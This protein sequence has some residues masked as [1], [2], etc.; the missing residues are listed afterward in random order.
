MKFVPLHVH[1]HYSLLDGMAKIDDLVGKAKA[2]GMEAMA[3]TDHGSMYGI[4]EFYQKAKKAGLKPILGIETYVAPYGRFNKRTKIDEERYHLILLAKNNLGYRN[5]LKL[6][7]IANLEGFY[8]KPRI[9]LEILDKYKDGLIGLSACLE[10]EIPNAILTYK[11]LDKAASV[12]E[13]YLKIFGPDNFFLELQHHP[14]IKEQNFVNEEL[15]KLAK[16]SGIGLVATNDTHYL[17]TEDAKAQDI[18][19]CV[20][21]NRKIQETNRL[22][23]MN[24]EFSLRT[25]KQMIKDFKDCPEAISNTE[26]I[27]EACNV[28]IEF[29]KNILPK[30]EVPGG[31]PAIE[32]LKKLCFEGLIFRYGG[33]LEENFNWQIDEKKILTRSQSQEFRKKEI[34]ERL[35]FELSVIE[36]TGFAPYFLIVADFINWAKDNGIVVGPGRGSAAGSIVAYLTRTTDIDPLAYD[37]LFERFLNPDRISMPDID[38]DFADIR[39]DEVIHYVEEKYGKDHVAQI[40]TFGTMAARAAVRDVGRAL[41]LPYSYCDK[42][43][44]M[45]PM[46][47][48]LKVA[49]EKVLDLRE[50][51]KK[52]KD[53][54]ELLDNAIKL[55]GVCRHAST[56]ACGV[57]ITPG[58]LDDYL[59][60][61]YSTSGDNVIVSQYSLHPVEDLGL[62]KMDF[63]GL[64]NLTTIE[65]TLETIEKIH[66]TKIEIEKLPLADKKTF[67]LLQKGETTGVF[68]LESSGMKRYLRQLKPTEFEDIIAMVAM[69]RPGPMEHIP[70][71]ISNKNGKTKPSYLHEKL[72]P[73]LKITNGVAI[74]QEQLLQ[75]ARSLAGFT[76][77]EADVLRKAVGKKIKSLL[78]EQENK[79]VNGCIK[80]GINKKTAEQIFAFIEPFAGYGFNRSHAACYALIAYQTAYLK[81]HYPAE[82]MAS[83]LTS[84][85]SN[86]DRVA[87]EV[88]EC[89][90][91]GIEVLAPDINESFT[92]FTV[93]AESLK[94]KKPRIRFGLLAIKNV[95]A[96]LTKAIIKE[97]KE[98]GPFQSMED[99]LSRIKDKD[100][101]KKSL[102]SLI[103]SGTLDQFGD[104]YE[105]LMNM[106]KLLNFVKVVN[107]QEAKLQD[108]LFA[109]TELKIKHNLIMD[110]YPP[111][112]KEKE[113]AWEKELLGL[114]VSDHPFTEYQKELD[115][116]ILTSTH[117]KKGL[118]AGNVRIA[119]VINNIKKVITQKG[120]IML[121]V[122]IEDT[123]NSLE[124][125]VFPS[126]Y[127]ETRETWLENNI[128]IISG[129]VSNKDGD[130]KVICNEV[131]TLSRDILADLKTKLQKININLQKQAKN[132][133]IFFKKIVTAETVAKL[134]KILQTSQGKNKVFLAVPI[135]ADR[136]RKIETNFFANFEDPILLKE[137]NNLNE[138]RFVKLM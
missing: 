78:I 22:S 34:L 133:F 65:N 131:K 84:D 79:F 6:V 130:F 68:Q 47:L 71:Y 56:H 25:T 108:S 48:K 112:S 40:I 138:V 95:G 15:K 50:E 109:L 18:L 93:V 114:Y 105:M 26:K 134:N 21:T 60:L 77:S 83:L 120:E 98:A 117:I 81:A 13:K 126:V 5:L 3:L 116:Y 2:D 125:I 16:K 103:K 30:F 76:L 90:T 137:L 43:A 72:E 136:F 58:S 19:L 132:I 62:L 127:N 70:E 99:F 69:Y 122:K 52:N 29:G 27:A 110:K 17:N 42:I 124:T 11:D 7:T 104:R 45:I 44:K 135:A 73:I 82:F 36:K 111:V 37:L 55:E 20:Q 67:E 9:D 4:I 86:I 92:R 97:R 23:M 24:D 14:Q 63:L 115:G 89:R 102:E 51:Y 31:M 64:S 8:Y 10:G 87:L 32:Y 128:V 85:L 46:N 61:Q 96:N 53:C 106:E 94:Q 119:G 59:P 101:N 100:L 33:K 41:G 80:N 75:I 49:L 39:R 66:E 54:K 113:L 121:F 38:T 107:N 129:T 35:E 12:L 123:Y 57:V 74:Y 1:S 28:D 91:M 118:G 88:N